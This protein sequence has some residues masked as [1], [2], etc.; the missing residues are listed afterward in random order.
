MKNIYY[1]LFIFSTILFF[2]SCETIDLDQTRDDS[3]ASPDL[4]NPYFAFNYIQLEL[5]DFVDSGN[6][7]T[8]AVTRQMAMTGG[9]TYQNAFEP[10][11]FDGN[12]TTAYGIL[13]AIKVVEA[14]APNEKFILGSSKVIKA[15][16]LMSLV[17][18]YGDVPLS[19]ALDP[20]ILNP[21][22]DSGVDVYKKAIASL[23]EGLAILGGDTGPTTNVID[24]YYNK[25]KAKWI[26][27]AKT[28]K[29]KLYNTARLAGSDLGV[30]IAQEISAIITAGDIIDTPTEDFAFK[31]GTNRNV[32]NSRHPL[33]NDQ[34]ELGG[35]AYIG[36]Y[37][38]WA[39][40]IEKGKGA[41]LFFDPRS[42]F[43]FWRQGPIPINDTNAI[44][45]R[46]RP[47]HYN[48]NEYNSFFD[49][50]NIRTPYTISNWIGTATIPTGGYLG[51]DHGNSTGIPPD[52]DT[53]AVA[54]LY[55]IGGKFEYN[56]GKTGSVQHS[57]TDGALGA[58]IMP[59]LL[60]SYVQ[61]MK[62]EA[63]LKLGISGNAKTELL[64]AIE[65]SIDKVTTF[66]LGTGNNTPLTPTNLT[67][68]AT[69]KANYLTFISTEYDALVNDDQRLELI[70]KEYYLAAWGNGIEVYNNYRRT[71]YPS[72]FQP[73]LELNSGPFYNAALY[74]ANAVSNN[75]NTPTN[76]RTRRV[77]WD[78]AALDLH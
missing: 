4:Y 25:D 35:G 2:S 33:Y 41:D 66:P 76:N 61:F 68:I 73:T 53:R 15:Y 56:T 75:P 60:S 55:P 51:R 29:L 30:D 47:T 57:G 10:V 54:G 36:N 14:K 31:Y 21:K 77:F 24:L 71:G 18:L 16:V 23:D 8:Q 70:M 11:N 5:A 62:A 32:P 69:K 44:P 6:S 17:D 65:K 59:M 34:Y 42:L 20:S 1:K 50:D 67:N 40:T 22:F 63:I 13:N 58:G 74:P 45:G 64:G 9:D 28:L 43:Y 3:Q 7:F 26:T 78:K 37:M 49:S 19:E 46:T 72:N 12:W 52:L 27:L 39:M 38:I 48:N